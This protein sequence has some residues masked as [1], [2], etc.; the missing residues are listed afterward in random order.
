MRGPSFAVDGERKSARQGIALMNDITDVNVESIC[1]VAVIVRA[2]IL[3]DAIADFLSNSFVMS[4]L[5]RSNSVQGQAVVQISTPWLSIGSCWQF[6][7]KCM[8]RGG[9]GSLNGGMSTSF[10]F[11]SSNCELKLPFTGR[12]L[13]M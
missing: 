10:S 13:E 8:R 5:L 1:Y 11:L 12:Y 2:R 9:R 3:T 7:R 4:Y 6:L